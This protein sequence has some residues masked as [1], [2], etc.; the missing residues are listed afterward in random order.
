M[1]VTFSPADGG[2]QKT[3]WAKLG[4]IDEQPVAADIQTSKAEQA[5]RRVIV[6]K[7]SRKVLAEAKGLEQIRVSAATVM[8]VADRKEALKRTAF[9]Y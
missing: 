7:G 5:L 2:P 6:E 4:S 1:P 9:S 3:I 8:M